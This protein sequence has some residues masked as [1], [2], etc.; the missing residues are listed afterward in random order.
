[1]ELIMKKY[2]KFIIVVAAI[3]ISILFIVVSLFLLNIFNYL[4]TENRKENVNIKISNACVSETD[5]YK[6]IIQTCNE[7]INNKPLTTVI[8]TIN[9]GKIEI[10]FYF[11]KY[12]NNTAEGGRIEGTKVLVDFDNKT[13][14]SIEYFNGSSKQYGTTVTP[15]TNLNSLNYSNAI[16]DYCKSNNE[17]LDNSNFIIRY[18]ENSTR[19]ELVN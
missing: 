9:E 4:H 3:I 16:D 10:E 17:I 14:K 15:L 13:I 1:M 12:I 8:T 6:S 5:V 19:V 18:T 11:V 2:K 7:Y